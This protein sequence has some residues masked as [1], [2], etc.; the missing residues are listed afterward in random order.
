MP[1]PGTVTEFTATYKMDKKSFAIYFNFEC[2][3]APVQNE[4]NVDEK[5]S[6]KK[7]KKKYQHHVP[8]SLCKVTESEFG[9]YK[10]ETIVYSDSDPNLLII[11][12]LDELE[13]VYEETMK[14]YKENQCEIDMTSKLESIICLF[15][16]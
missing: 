7:K 3:T 4:E 13:R 6:K 2:I 1:E 10:E 8:C 16:N 15:I 5:T 14:C 12:F 11:T 9:D